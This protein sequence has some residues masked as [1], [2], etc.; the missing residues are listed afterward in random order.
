MTRSDARNSHHQPALRERQA[1]AEHEAAAAAEAT[2]Q[3]EQE[4]LSATYATLLDLQEATVAQLEKIAGQ[5]AAD[6]RSM[7]EELTV[8]LASDDDIIETYADFAAMNR[9]VEAYNISQDIN[10]QKLSDLQLLLRQPYFAKVSLR[11]KPD[12]PAQDIYIG[13]AGMSDERCRRIVVDW[14]SPVAETYYN[15][16]NGPTSYEANGRTIHAD[17]LLRRQFDIEADQ[18]RA[19]FDTTVA[20]QDELLLASLSERRS[21][22]MK[23]ITATIQKEQNQVV[24]HEDVPALL[25]SGVAGS[26]KTSVMLQRIAYLFYRNRETLDPRE[27]II[28][29]PNPLFRRYIDQ[30]L[31]DMGERNPAMLTWGDL[32]SRLMPP[33]LAKAADR[34]TLADLEAIDAATE[35]FDLHGGDFCDIACAGVTL[36]RGHS[37]HKA[38]EKF[39]NVP[40]GPH[41]MVL[42]REELERR[43][44][45]RLGQMAAQ[46]S[47]QDEL[48]ALPLEEQLRLFGAPFEP[49]D[50]R[51]ARQLALAY[52]TD[53]YAAAF[54]AI[55]RDDWLRVERVGARLL[56]ETSLAPCQWLYLKMALTGMAERDAKYVMV[57]EVQDC[58][59]AQL[60]V[61]ARYFP[62]ARFLLLGDPNQA[63]APGL[64]TFEEIRAV[65][66]RARGSVS[67]CRLVTSYR[68]AP[69]ITELFER[70][71]DLGEGEARIASVRR[72][73]EPPVFVKCA[74]RSVHTAELCRAIKIAQE[75]VEAEGG[76]A[77]V[78]VPR[79]KEARRLA[80]TLAES[81]MEPPM[82][83]DDQA[84]LPAQGVVIVA[85]KL[86]KG[87]E[88]DQVIV[89]DACK[90]I[91]GSDDLA[92]RRLYTT[93]SRAT[94]HLTVLSH[95]PLSPWLQEK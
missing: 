14:R 43:L 22:R 12:E 79:Q 93:L 39:R 54:E 78:I 62:R 2:F 83:L 15:Q 51:E 8:N 30:V 52:V 1:H 47:V 32:A 87:L 21:D 95:G 16:A 5:A 50:E 92:R 42:V 10:A 69:G 58:T 86:A 18:L 60:A 67:E 74:D 27:V 88:F 40:A 57:D 75:R 11:F 25:V 73:E 26:G 41:R 13:N 45:A 80:R 66:E 85:L 76:L 68:S 38:W 24:R 72:A 49:E 36:V 23:A 48:A 29:T 65:F 33:A 91:F 3:Q 19:Y 44:R 55:E 63:I 84:D 20:I 64:A 7:G 28:V 90:A 70:V 77:A 4:H 59:A 89:A 81:F 9:I 37:A 94:K 56:G 6:K 82:V 71:A 46:E 17:L 34:T 31:P 61:M 53:R 35:G